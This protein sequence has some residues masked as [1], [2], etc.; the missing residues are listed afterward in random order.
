M[1]LDQ[2][3]RAVRRSIGFEAQFVS[4]TEKSA[5]LVSACGFQYISID[6]GEDDGKTDHEES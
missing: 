1:I 6:T 3:G 4:E 5:D 2:Y